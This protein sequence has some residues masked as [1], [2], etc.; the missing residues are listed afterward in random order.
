M[1]VV[2][3]LQIY[4]IRASSIS[5]TLEHEAPNCVT[6]KKK[7]RVKMKHE[8]E[9]KQQQLVSKE[10]NDLPRPWQQTALDGEAKSQKR[11]HKSTDATNS[12]KEELP[13]AGRKLRR[14]M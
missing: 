3:T 8:S 1:N 9:S 12:N 14:R 5:S 13:K 6:V 11:K 2:V 7:T 10:K 4:I